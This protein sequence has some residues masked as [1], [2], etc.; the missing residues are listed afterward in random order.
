MET[1]ELAKQVD[2]MVVVGGKNSG[3]TLRLVRISESTGTPTFFIEHEDE[4][5]MERL[6]SF[7]SIGVVGGTSTPLWILKKVVKRIEELKS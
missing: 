7:S 2:G 4:L 5:D 1:L 6:K 3:N